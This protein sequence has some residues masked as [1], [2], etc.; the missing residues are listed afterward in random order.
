MKRR[1]DSEN[2]QDQVSKNVNLYAYFNIVLFSL[3]I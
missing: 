3:I 1:D 2:S